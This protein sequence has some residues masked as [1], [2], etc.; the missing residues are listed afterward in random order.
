M[1]KR[2]QV[3]GEGRQV[4]LK[5]ARTNQNRVLMTSAENTYLSLLGGHFQNLI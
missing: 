4:L 3:L 1:E 2:G 5:K